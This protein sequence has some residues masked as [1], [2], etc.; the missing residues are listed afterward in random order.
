MDS[1]VTMFFPVILL[2]G[3]GVAWVLARL[4]SL[5]ISHT[6]A[7]QKTV[8]A[9]YTVP[10]K[11]TPGEL[12]YIIDGVFGA[13]ELLATLSVLYAHGLIDLRPVR[14][15]DFWVIAQ[16]EQSSAPALDD[17]ESAVLGYLRSIP[18]GRALWSQLRSALSDVAGA[19]SDFDEAIMGSLVGKELLSRAG[20]TAQ[21]F[22]I[23][24]ASV[25]IAAI[26]FTA[27]AFRAYLWLHM[28]LGSD[29][30][31]DGFASL[32]R[33]IAIGVVAI[34][35]LVLWGC[36]LSYANLLVY[37]YTRRDGVPDG[38]TPALRELWPEV[39]GF[40][41]FLRETEYVRLQHDRNPKDPSLPYCLALGLDPGFIRALQGQDTPD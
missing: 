11:L 10:D 24:F 27:V 25:V 31:S 21:L 20:L 19:R 39:A 16:P 5:D 34:A 6:R 7:K 29:A 40:Q 22:R 38:A 41:L 33:Q 1:L 28:A 12:G 17:G 15:D 14:T 2:G 8:I 36:C 23:R 26:G 18:Q 4:N 30:R 13:N 9:E 3:V 35:A 32:D 37:I